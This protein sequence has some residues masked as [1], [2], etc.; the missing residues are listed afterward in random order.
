MKRIVFLLL[1]VACLLGS[2][3][4][5][6]AG[7]GNAS[8]FG[9]NALSLL[10]GYTSDGVDFTAR[11]LLP[12]GASASGAS[13]TMVAPK[14]CEGVV[15]RFEDEG[16]IALFGEHAIALAALPLP[17]LC[18]SLLRPTEAVFSD[19]Y[20]ENEIRTSVYLVSENA[21]TYRTRVGEG[22]P[23]EAEGRVGDVLCTLRI[24]SVE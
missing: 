13:V 6:G 3:S 11:V 24:L 21:Y 1:S 20:T 10:V 14:E 12:A 23:F 17:L 7:G 5:R 15:Y 4:C 8:P 19:S 2:V 18:L 22:F 9:E 16:A